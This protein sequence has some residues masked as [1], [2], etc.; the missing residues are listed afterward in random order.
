MLAVLIERSKEHNHFNGLVPH[1]VD[2]G[3]SILQYADDTILFVEDDLDK[4]KNL[5][6]VLCAFEKLSGLKINFHKSELFC[7]GETKDRVAEYV[8]LFGCKEGVLPF[9]Y[10]GI[11]M[12][13]RKLANKDWSTIEERFQ[14]KLSSWKGKMLSSGGRLVLINSILSSLPM[15]MMS[16][17]RIPKGVLKKLDYYRSRFFWQCDEHKKK[18]RLARWSILRKPKSVG[19][20]GILDLDIQNKYLLSKWLFRLVNEDGMWQSILKRKYLQNKTLTQVEK[21]KGDSHFWSG[22]MEVKDLFLRMG[23]FKIRDGTQTR[24][25]EDL[26]LGD[27][28]LM[29]AYPSLYRIVRKK[30]VTGSGAKYLSA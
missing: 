3:I 15:F 26:W 30:N 13:P 19:G 14:K 21:K 12:S 23:R 27:E 4:A 29:L 1:L 18:Y 24:F 17:F 10:L 2:G 22:L 7:F 8:E 28:L 11:P 20:L 6:L 25:W 5:K 9:R 16:F